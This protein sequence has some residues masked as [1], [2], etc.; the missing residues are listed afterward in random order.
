MSQSLPLLTRDLPGVGGAIKEHLEDFQV[1]EIP[2]YEPSGEG[3]H[4][5]F[6]V[7][8]KG[9]PT[10]AAI[11]R[12][13]RHLGVRP[14][15][16]GVA[17][18]KDA[19]AVTTQWMSIEHVDEARLATLQDAQLS[20]GRVTRHTNKL[21]TGHLAGN[22]F[23]IRI[24]NPQPGA[25]E[26]A[27]AALDVLAR[28]GVPNFF[29]S[30]RFGSRGDG[31]EL[32]RALA[33][34]ND[35]EFLALFL[36]RPKED[37]P[38]DCTA[39]REAFD[40]GDLEA[41]MQLW[42]PHYSAERRILAA[43]ARK[44]TAARAIAALDKRMKRL[45]VSAFQSRIFNEI[46]ARRIDS[47]DQVQLGDWAQKTDTGGVFLVEDLAADAPRAATFQ[48][49]PTGPIF[50]R[51]CRIAQGEPGRLEREVMAQ[52]RLEDGELTKVG[53]L[54]L[55]GTRRPLRF[56]IRDVAVAAGE[57]QAGAFVEVR[58]FAPSGCYA[59]VVLGEVMKR[60]IGK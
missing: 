46:L 30:Q 58:F 47:I 1:A 26:A 60:G 15:D 27:Q 35:D 44:R 22:R 20:I 28:R 6:E 53:S 3:T 19:R 56:P 5:Y 49:S 51:R 50:G 2:L 59:T 17:G 29:G 13:A 38:P 57:D 52:H 39:A 42:P 34:G 32:G 12:I 7:T 40:R 23:G 41:A 31:S 25:L 33:A 18:M 8:K 9:I 14:D 37:D 55:D 43:F 36:G 54:K 24:R 4:L 45:Y 10:P 16:V 48:I 11:Q 21:R